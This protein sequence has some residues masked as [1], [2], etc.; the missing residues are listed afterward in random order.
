MLLAYCMPTTNSPAYSRFSSDCIHNILTS[1][2]PQVSYLYMNTQRWNTLKWTD[3]FNR[4]LSR[5]R[6]LL[7]GMEMYGGKELN[8][9]IQ[10]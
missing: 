8:Q 4:V 9:Y 10:L 3:W 6:T 5:T 1:R 2:Y 7:V